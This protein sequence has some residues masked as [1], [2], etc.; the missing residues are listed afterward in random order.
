MISMLDLPYENYEQA[1][2]LAQYLI[3][4]EVEPQMSNIT[5]HL[6][7]MQ[8]IKRHNTAAGYGQTQCLHS[9]QSA[10]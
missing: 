1:Y 8:F 5:F 10:P 2:L 4:A 9:F 7:T 3:N 6:K